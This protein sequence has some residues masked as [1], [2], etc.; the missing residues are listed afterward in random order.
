[1][2][3]V[4]QFAKVPPFPEG[5]PTADIP[6]ISLSK[7]LVNDVAASE[8]LFKASTNTGFLL[9]DLKDSTIGESILTDVQAAF[10]TSKNFYDCSPEEKSKYPKLTSALG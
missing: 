4:E 10:V 3:T 1:M 2:P 7:L 9:L 8:A 6:R 5:V